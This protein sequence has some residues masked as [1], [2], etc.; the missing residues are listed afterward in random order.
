M[1]ARV[2]TGISLKAKS[3][4]VTSTSPNKVTAATT[5]IEPIDRLVLPAAKS[6]VP[7]QSA[8]AEPRRTGFMGDPSLSDAVGADQVLAGSFEMPGDEI[9]G[10]RGIAHLERLED[11]AM[12][13]VV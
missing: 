13:L 6:S 9:G 11:G 3:D 10:G 12:L 4:N 2:M 5:R 7:R 1:S 8:A